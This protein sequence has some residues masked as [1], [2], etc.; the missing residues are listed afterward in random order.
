MVET[1][2]SSGLSTDHYPTSSIPPY[3]PY[4]V[5]YTPGELASDV[6]GDG[7]I[8]LMDIRR[9]TMILMSFSGVRAAPLPQSILDLQSWNTP[10]PKPVA[11]LDGDGHA[12]LVVVEALPGA[13]QTSNVI[14]FNGDGDGYQADSRW[15]L[16]L[17]GVPLSVVA[18]QADEDPDLELLAV[19]VDW[20]SYFYAQVVVELRTVVIDSP[21]TEHPTL[22]DNPGRW[23]TWD[24][25]YLGGSAD[26]ATPLVPLG[27]LDGDGRDEVLLIGAMTVP[28]PID[29]HVL[30]SSR[31]YDVSNPLR[32]MGL[33][34]GYYVGATPVDVDLDGQLDLVATTEIPSFGPSTYFIQ[35]WFGPFVDPYEPPDTG[36]P[37][38]TG[39]P[40]DTGLP[41][42]TGPTQPTGAT[43]HTGT[44]PDDTGPTDP[45]DPAPAATPAPSCGCQAPGG[46]APWLLLTLAGLTRRRRAPSPATS[47]LPDIVS[48]WW[49]A[50]R[51][52]S[53]R[54]PRRW[55]R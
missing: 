25:E 15:S 51:R 1:I 21:G 49:G 30:G 28:G 47:A 5:G 39:L 23:P 41:G 10:K 8:D 18:L 53:C 6:D 26:V 45:G 4:I 3:P 29:L 20:Y 2:R 46:Q 44:P 52:S 43:T 40:D 55:S 14:V 48:G 12:E 54:P 16:A 24:H 35:V 38:D 17:D 22:V 33:T 27:D 42:D 34:E 9:E 32:S 36:L 7:T 11:D 37:Q 31:D 13:P 50:R 19:L